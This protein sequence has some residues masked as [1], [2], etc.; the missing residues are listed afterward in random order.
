MVLDP[1]R[2]SGASSSPWLEG[3]SEVQPRRL[4]EDAIADVCVVGGGIAGLT[5]ALLLQE[6]GRKVILLED[7]RIG[8]GE[9]GRTTAHL[10]SILDDRFSRLER[11]HGEH[12]ARLAYESH[13]AAITQIESLVRKYSIECEFERLPGY[14][15]GSPGDS[16]IL[17]EEYEAAGRIGVQ[18]VKRL[19]QAPLPDFDSGPCLAFPDQG[20]FHPFQYLRALATQFLREGGQL[21]EGSHV[22]DV[23]EGDPILVRT[24]A[25]LSVRAR[26]LVIATNAPIVSRVS[27][28]LRQ[29]PYRTYV[30]GLSIPNDAAP[31]ALYW[32]TEDPYHFVRFQKRD[33]D[34][35]LIVGGEDH[36]TGQPEGEDAQE[37]Y[38]K[39]ESWARTRF[40][41]AS[42]VQYAWS[43]QIMEPADGLAFIGR[44]KPSGEHVYIATGDSGH[45]MTHG[46]IAGMLLRDLILGRENPWAELYKP[47]RL[48]LRSLGE[49]AKENL[50]VIPEYGKWL[51]GSEAKA[52]AAI[53][54]GEGRV[55]RRGFKKL[56]CYRE[57]DGQLC[58]FSAACPHLGAVLTWNNAEKTW[59]CPAHGSRFTAEGK[60]VSGPA[61]RDLKR[62]GDALGTEEERRPDVA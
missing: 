43:G 14:L 56:A 2:S 38:A 17:D 4:A 52:E 37:R 25:G 54:R 45:G 36:K 29:Y 59:D 61:N 46:T 11:L 18:G 23:E 34:S 15:L 8:S 32:D 24:S 16:D 3:A 28:P 30:V 10:A 13:A 40:P 48:T 62:I 35:L 6:S 7:G 9:T 47:S 27:I 57:E 5:T 53:P 33:A 26:D 58:V 50:N 60:V 39:L 55:L 31:K 51:T 22:E 21:F 12:G 41:S 49:V 1:D 19:G 42:A 44:H 20:Q